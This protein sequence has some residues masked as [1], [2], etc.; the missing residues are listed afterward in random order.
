MKLGFE[1]TTEG[2]PTAVG[3]AGFAG[4]K[5]RPLRQ[6][7]LPIVKRRGSSKTALVTGASSGI[8]R[9]LARLVAEDGLDLVLVARRSDRLEDLARELSVAHGVTAR[10][11]AKD[12]TSPSSPKEIIQ[13]LER[14]R[15]DV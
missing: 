12:L 3:S 2:R 13:E 9:E 7:N 11:L 14:E 8:G 1:P 5:S 15:L 6:C 10:V 4:A